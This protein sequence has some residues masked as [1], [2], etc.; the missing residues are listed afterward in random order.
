[1]KKRKRKKLLPIIAFILI[2]EIVIVVLIMLKRGDRLPTHINRSS[3]STSLVEPIIL[4]ITVQEL[5]GS[6][7]SENAEDHNSAT[8]YGSLLSDTDYCLENRIHAAETV[9]ADTVNLIFAGDVCFDPTYTHF[10]SM[11]QRGGS[12]DKGFSED[13]LKFM[14]DADIFMCNFECTFTDRGEPVP[15][16]QY[17]LRSSPENVRYLLDMGV[18]IVALANNHSYDYGEISLTDTLDTLNGVALPY[19][20]A[21]RNIDEASHPVSFIAN[22]LRISIINATQIEKLDRPDTPGAT[23]TRPGTFRC[24]YDDTILDKIREAR[25][26]SD[27]VITYIHWGE[28]LQEEI[29]WAQKELAPKLV[30]AGANLV[31]GDHP[32]ILQKIDYI[33]GVPVVYSLGNYWF[34]GKNRDTGLLQL[35][36]DSS[37]NPTIRFIPATEPNMVTTI[38]SDNEK[39]RILNH[40]REISPKANID[41]DGYITEKR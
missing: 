8:R 20:G 38:A 17:T 5:Q 34:N 10:A 21:G 23:D 30:E 35:S 14:R 4:P 32:H 25:N 31:I 19:V 37:A 1:M 11:L 40:L 6:N 24:W 13:T 33:N 39:Q 15:D 7:V 36:L 16:K 22:D 3:N 26:H 28:E 12:I 41:D 2:L 18:D 29:D 27:Y 9:S